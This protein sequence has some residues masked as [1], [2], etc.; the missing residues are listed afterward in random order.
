MPS[1]VALRSTASPSRWRRHDGGGCGH[2]GGA[3]CRF[4][5]SGTHAR[6]AVRDGYLLRVSHDDQWNI[7][8][9]TCRILCE[10]GMEVTTGTT[11][12]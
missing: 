5:V 4:S 12:E 2:A 3:A 11:N 9:R 7:A 8:L 1:V 6:A 10:P